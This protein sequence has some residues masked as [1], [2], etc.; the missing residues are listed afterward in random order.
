[1][2]PQTATYQG[3]IQRAIAV[4]GAVWGIAV[5]AHVVRLGLSRTMGDDTPVII[6][7]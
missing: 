3:L 5:A 7:G 2:A 6:D 1:M 4:S